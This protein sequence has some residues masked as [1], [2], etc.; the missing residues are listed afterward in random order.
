MLRIAICDDEQIFRENV[1][2]YVEQ[3]LIERDMAYEIETFSSGKEFL[4]LGVEKL[5][6]SIIFL[7]IN[8]DEIDG[9]MTAKKI[10]ECNSEVY[11]VFVTAYIDYSLEGYKVDAARYLLKGS[12]NFDASIY[13]CM[14]AILDK[15]NYVISKKTFKFNEGEKD[16]SLER[17]L[18]IESRLHKL[19]FHIM[20]DKMVVYSLYGTLNDLEK[21]MEGSKFFRIHQSFLVNLKHI[22]AVTTYKV[23]LSN[24]EELSIPKSRYKDVKNAFVAYKGEL[25]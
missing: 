11:I 1:K 21:D 24:D 17:I 14:D 8:M 20:K 25:W 16:I 12:C 6:Y 4:E 19:E 15:M 5:R 10:R 18:Y 3:Y 22:K 23:I 2:K 9:I 13:E 7:D